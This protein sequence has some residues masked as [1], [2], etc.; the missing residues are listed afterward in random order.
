MAQNRVHCFVLKR[1]KLEELSKSRPAFADKLATMCSIKAVQ[2]G[3]S[4]D[5]FETA[6][7][8]TPGHRSFSRMDGRIEELKASLIHDYEEKLQSVGL[9]LPGKKTAFSA[10]LWMQW[11]Y[12][13][14]RDKLSPRASLDEGKFDSKSWKKVSCTFTAAGQMLFIGH[15]LQSLQAG[16]LLSLGILKEPNGEDEDNLTLNHQNGSTSELK[17]NS[18]RRISFLLT[19]T[20]AS[21]SARKV[22]VSSEYIQPVDELIEAMKIVTEM[23]HKC[24]LECR[25]EGLLLHNIDVEQ[26][27]APQMS[28]HL[29]RHHSMSQICPDEDCEWPR[30]TPRPQELHSMGP[31]PNEIHN[32]AK[33]LT[34][35]Y[36]DASPA[37]QIIM[38]ELHKLRAEQGRQAQ[39]QDALHK[40]IQQ[41]LFEMTDKRG[42]RP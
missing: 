16:T 3:V 2:Y 1:E 41:A 28:T 31:T 26:S 21:T 36:A 42:L 32:D 20:G 18:N 34:T 23:Q 22:T 33:R 27:E 11:Q 4:N 5:A 37:L 6:I 35:A 8:D 9:C 40:Q 25:S 7:Q 10:Q 12:V 39:H 19:K 14:T 13:C 30:T 17:K 24:E 38:E 15:D 29:T